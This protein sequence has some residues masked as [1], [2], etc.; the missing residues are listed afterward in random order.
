MSPKFTVLQRG[1]P[2][3][4]YE[5]GSVVRNPRLAVGG[6]MLVVM[7]SGAQVAKIDPTGEQPLEWIATD[8]LR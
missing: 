8:K 3:R 6:T 1:K 4:V 7:A 2:P 5:L